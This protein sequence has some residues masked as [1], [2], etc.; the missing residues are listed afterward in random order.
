MRK[1]LI[2]MIAVLALVCG[3]GVAQATLIDGSGGGLN[4]TSDTDSGL[5]WLDMSYSLNQSYNTV[6]GKLADTTDSLYGWRHASV[7]EVVTFWEQATGGDWFT[8]G[9]LSRY[10]GWTDAVAAYVGYTLV[11]SGT[12]YLYGLTS[13]PYNTSMQIFAAL[14]D[15]AYGAYDGAWTNVYIDRDS[16]PSYMASW[17]VRSTQTGGGPNPVPEPATILLL[18][19]GLAGLAVARRRKKQ[20]PAL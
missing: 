6:V 17:L 18:G 7:S 4:W 8:H 11:N 16:N 10:E 3:G 5:D 13:D 20:Q 15:P 2:G 19:S 1:Q 14:Q 9:Y 12:Q